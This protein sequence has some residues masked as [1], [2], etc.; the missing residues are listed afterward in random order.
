MEL[1]F[2]RHLQAPNERHTVVQLVC[3]LT[4]LYCVW[5]SYVRTRVCVYAYSVVNSVWCN[6]HF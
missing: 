2:I 5:V 6:D 4:D 1:R 3:G